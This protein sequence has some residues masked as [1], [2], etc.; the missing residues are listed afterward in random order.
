MDGR[1]IGTVVFPFA[2]IKLFVTAN[3]E[4]RAKRRYEELV[5]KGEN[6]SLE[7]VV[8]NVRTRDYID[9]NREVSPL[10]KA[11]DAIVLDTSRMT[12]AEQLEWLEEIVK[13]KLAV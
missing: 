9:E 1:D 6:V 13:E 3:V 11:D 7:E 4:V 8:D 12:P 10:K 5:G 2:D